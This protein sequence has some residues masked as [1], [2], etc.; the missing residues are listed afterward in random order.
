MKPIKNF[1]T[2][3]L[4]LS[5]GFVVL[6]TAVCFISQT[7]EAKTRFGK[8]IS[9]MVSEASG[10]DIRVLSAELRFPLRPHLEKVSWKDENGKNQEI[11]QLDLWIPLGAL[12]YT[13]P[14]AEIRA[15]GLPSLPDASITVLAL[16]GW[17][18]WSALSAESTN[19]DKV[20][21]NGHLSLRN[22]PWKIS[23]PFQ[24]REN[25]SASFPK[26]QAKGTNLSLEG[27]ATLNSDFEI[28]DAEISA[29]VFFSNGEVN[30]SSQI[31]G[32]LFAPSAEGEFS[33]DKLTFK[34]IPVSAGS[35]RFNARI[36]SGKISGKCFGTAFIANKK[37]TL[38]SQFFLLEGNILELSDIALSSPLGDLTGHIKLNLSNPL[39]SGSLKGNI[40]KAAPIGALIHSSFDGTLSFDANFKEENE[41]QSLSLIFNSDILSRGDMRI[42]K[43]SGTASLQNIF[44]DPSGTL[45]IE[46]EDAQYKHLKFSKF[47]AYTEIGKEKTPFIFEGNGYYGDSKLPL[48]IYSEGSWESNDTLSFL[49]LQ[50]FEGKTSRYPFR[51]EQ[52]ASFSYSPTTATLTPL[53]LSIGEGMITGSL[54]YDMQDVSCNMLVQT[55]PLEF[56]SLF[57][58]NIPLTGETSGQISLSGSPQS[59]MGHSIFSWDNVRYKEGELKKLPP[60]SGNFQADFA[61]GIFEMKA[62]LNDHPVAFETSLP[63]TLSFAPLSIDIERNKEIQGN[64]RYK[65]TISPIFHL[66]LNDSHRLSGYTDT[67]LRL[68]G[69]LLK[70]QVE[71]YSELRYCRYESLTTKSSFKDIHASFRGEDSSLFLDGLTATDGNSGKMTASGVWEID[72]L[73]SLPFHATINLTDTALVNHDNTYANCNG[74]IEFY[75]DI[76]EASLT[77]ELLLNDGNMIIPDHFNSDLPSLNITFSE[78]SINPSKEQHSPSTYPLNLDVTVKSKKPF[79]I[80]GKGLHSDWDGHLKL[81]QKEGILQTV[82][83]LKLNKGTFRFSNKTFVI[84]EGSLIF[85]DNA[86]QAP[87]IDVIADL[88]LDNIS[89]KATLNGP[90]SSPKLSFVSVPALSLNEILAQIMFDRQISEISPIEALQIG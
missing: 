40:H 13:Q 7:H 71:G 72:Y 47:S 24:Y 83:T 74:Q 12:F 1:F 27:S 63:A 52:E 70:P 73:K 51:L 60:L 42:K 45:N 88:I 43:M 41:Q 48:Q 56:G 86:E 87:S 54:S 8:L 26:I 61:A 76:Y 30:I 85:H 22:G 80:S 75:G 65:G 21:F 89:V 4:R 9:K 10:Q 37:T 59:P 29:R 28:K 25:K 69:T 62:F 2:L 32:P 11:Q 46:G 15:K 81:T 3:I 18:A 39:L 5:F 79:S 90:F 50:R 17:D 84:T 19:S 66:L 31:T 38:D 35:G 44:Q 49:H 67:A 34:D 33:F 36:S 64:I 57:F 23:S 58:P 53:H 14:S 16:E 78:P 6:L 77:G 55:V 20:L 68:S 82:G